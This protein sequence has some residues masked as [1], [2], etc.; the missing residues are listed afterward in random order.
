MRKCFS[1]NVCVF[2]GG[3]EEEEEEKQHIFVA[4]CRVEKYQIN[5]ESG[6]RKSMIG[7]S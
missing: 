4:I 5:L 7:A 1:E 6:F 3:G 2:F